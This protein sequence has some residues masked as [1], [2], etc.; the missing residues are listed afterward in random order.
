[1]KFVAGRV[2]AHPLYPLLP[3]S[4]HLHFCLCAD[5]HLCSRRRMLLQMLLLGA[6]ATSDA[7]PRRSTGSLRLGIIIR[8]DSCAFQNL[9]GSA[10]I[11]TSLP[12]AS[13]GRENF[14]HRTSE[15]E[16]KSLQ[17]A[18][19]CVTGDGIGQLAREECVG[20][21]AM[22]KS[23]PLSNSTC[24]DGISTESSATLPSISALHSQENNSKH[25]LPIMSDEQKQNGSSSGA[26]KVT[27]DEMNKHNDHGNLW[28]A[29]GGK[30]AYTFLFLG[31][32]AA[33]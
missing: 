17:F 26:R 20:I 6:M 24:S 28:L 29:I 25:P 16:I 15:S 14:G 12:R 22:K 23:G 13:L 27:M 7:S 19:S 18:Q 4:L 2:D 9:M 21:P 31:S 3:F 8:R 11:L 30:G 33:A 32:V 5:L 1:M 10:C